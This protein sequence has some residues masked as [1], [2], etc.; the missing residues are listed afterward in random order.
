MNSGS[1]CFGDQK[2]PWLNPEWPLIIKNERPWEE[3]T[4]TANVGIER[5][6]QCNAA[7]GGDAG[8]ELV[9]L[10]PKTIDWAFNLIFIFIFPTSFLIF[11]PIKRLYNQVPEIVKQK[12]K[13]QLS[14]QRRHRDRPIQK[15]YRGS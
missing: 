11:L 5:I 10:E 2:K 12:I 8:I 14:G 3:V 13:I 4:T 6:N 9:K 1:G 7:G 15:W